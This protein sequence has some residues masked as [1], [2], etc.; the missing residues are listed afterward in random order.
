MSDDGSVSLLFEGR[1]SFACIGDEPSAS[2]DGFDGPITHT[3]SESESSDRAHRF[4]FAT[5]A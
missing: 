5:S 3:I 2:L 4:R 1:L